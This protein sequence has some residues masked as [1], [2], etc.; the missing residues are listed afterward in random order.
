MRMRLNGRKNIPPR[1]PG[2]G[3][4]RPNLGGDTASSSALLASEM[5]SSIFDDESEVGYF[6]LFCSLDRGLSFGAIFV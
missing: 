3:I 4:P 2:P 1:L 6:I 5:E